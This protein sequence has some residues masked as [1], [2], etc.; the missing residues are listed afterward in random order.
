MKS[1]E[2]KEQNIQ[3]LNSLLP[4]HDSGFFLDIDNR[5]I[6]YDNNPMLSTVGTKLALTKEHIL[7]LKKCSED[8]IYFIEN[9]IKIST[10][11]E[12]E[13]YPTLRK[14]Q[15]NIIQQYTKERFNLFMAGRQSSKSITTLLYILWKLCFKPNTVV[16]I[17]AHKYSMAYENL[18]RL[19][20]MYVSI[21]LWLKPSVQSWN[22]T[23]FSNELGSKVYI[24][25]TTEDSFRGLSINLLF[26]DECVSGDTVITVRNKKTGIIENITIE[27][28][29][30][31][32][33][34]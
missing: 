9:Y 24:S 3:Y 23:S 2:E 16:G 21:P 1:Q 29:Y 31:R 12:G 14:Y 25:A 27:E 6:H 11:D 28:L 19:K 22:K 18:Q 34:Y 33:D 26:I 4:K 17:C 13:Q 5:K 20:N 8:Y 30:N 7:E 15:K 10:L 32:I